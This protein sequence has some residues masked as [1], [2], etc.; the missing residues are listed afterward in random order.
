M[1]EA[2]SAY[3][4][5]VMFF[6]IFS[7]LVGII[8][9][10]GKYKNYISVVLG[11]ILIFVAAKP[12][13][14]LFNVNDIVSSV[15]RQIDEALTANGSTDDSSAGFADAQTLRDDMIAQS[16]NVQLETQLAP[17]VAPY[18]YGVARAEGGVGYDNLSLSSVSVWLT[19]E[20]AQSGGGTAQPDGVSPIEQIMVAPIVIG[21]AA[22]NAAASPADDTQ[23]ILAQIKKQIADFYNI[24]VENIYL[25]IQKG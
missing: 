2:F 6:I 17:M 7:A 4:K 20:P 23:P 3:I 22:P 15:T 16:V 8:L 12:L 24:P 21:T 14:S 13:S 11:F 25:S 9:P 10:S 18:G 19:E 5:T 1:L